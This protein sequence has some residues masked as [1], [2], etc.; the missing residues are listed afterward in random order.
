LGK[1]LLNIGVK[2]VINEN[3]IFQ[4]EKISDITPSSI[5]VLPSFIYTMNAYLDTI[6]YVT[7]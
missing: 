5:A 2:L 7:G 1:L 6:N 3:E 4:N